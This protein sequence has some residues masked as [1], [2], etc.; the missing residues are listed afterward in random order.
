MVR[1]E[2]YLEGVNEL[3]L[4]DGLESLIIP[5]AGS[6]YCGITALT[7]PESV[8][9]IELR[10][11]SNL[12]D[13]TLPETAVLAEGCF[14]GC[15]QIEDLTIPKGNRTLYGVCVG[16]TAHVVLPDDV[17]EVR[18]PISN[19]DPFRYNTESS[20]SSLKSIDLGS[21]R[22]LTDGALSDCVALER[23]TLP[24]SL[25]EL[26]DGVFSGCAQLRS[27]QGGGNVRQIGNS[28]FSACPAL[29]GFGDLT[30]NVTCAGGRPEHGAGRH[31]HGCH[32]Q[33]D[34]LHRAADQ[35]H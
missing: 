4:P 28:C 3:S 10:N 15:Y 32:R 13:I 6:S 5:D 31:D 19:G 14:S 20:N 7:V 12:T 11:M 33:R 34:G 16:R 26:G 1:I 2:G 9:Y 21:V 22:V 29:T 27:V 35:G 24:D 25:I 18:G 17:L 30:A 8:N 23:V